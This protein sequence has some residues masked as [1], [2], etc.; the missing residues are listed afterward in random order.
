MDF[1]VFIVFHFMDTLV[2]IVIHRD[3]LCCLVC[4][5]QGC[6]KLELGWGPLWNVRSYAVGCLGYARH[7]ALVCGYLT[8]AAVSDWTTFLLTVLNATWDSR[9]QRNDCIVY[10]N[11]YL[12]CRLAHVCF[13]FEAGSKGC[14]CMYVSCVISKRMQAA[15][16]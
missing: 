2:L 10:Q 14:V 3:F 8:A 12:V 9:R 13:V 1:L 11:R 16:L 5:P 15:G 7:Q 4:R 6:N